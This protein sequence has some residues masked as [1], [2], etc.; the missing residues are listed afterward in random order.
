RRPSSPPPPTTG[1]IDDPPTSHGLLPIA[2]A[3]RAGDGFIDSVD[4][5]VN[6]IDSLLRRSASRTPDTVAVRFADRDWSYRALDDAVSRAAAGLTALGLEPGARIAAFGVNS[7][8]YL[9]GFLATVRAGL[10]HVPINFALKAGEL[11]HLLDDSGAAV[12]LV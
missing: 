6:T 5:R 4:V 10:V 1:R 11:R 2:T 12:V 9:I 7:D 3:G 8:A